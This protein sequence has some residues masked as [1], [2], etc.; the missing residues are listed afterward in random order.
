[1]SDPILAP[2]RVEL[3]ERV[4]QGLASFGYTSNALKEIVAEGK[5][6]GE[7]K[8]APA[9]PL[10]CLFRVFALHDPTPEEILRRQLGVEFYEACQEAGLWKREGVGVISSIDLTIQVDSFLICDSGDMRL[11]EIGLYWVMRAGLS[12]QLVWDAVPVKPYER[13]LDL[14]CGSGVLAFLLAPQAK[15]IVAVDRNPRA[16]NFGRFGAAM[17]GLAHVEFRES[18]CYSAVA[19]ETFDAIVCNPPFVL[20]PDRQNYYRDG[21]MDGDG[22]AQQVL[23]EAPAHLR[24]GGMAFIVCDVAATRTEASEERLCG[25]L[26]ARGCDVFAIGEPVVE[27]RQYA[28]GWLRIEPEATKQQQEERW[29]ERFDELGVTGIRNWLVVLRK[30]T[31]GGPNWVLLDRFPAKTEGHF[32]H[33]IDRRFRCQD[34]VRMEDAAFWN[35]RLRLAPDARI[36]KV[37]RP[38]NGQWVAE[39]AEVTFATGLMDRSNVDPR[40]VDFLLLFDGESTMEEVLMQVAGAMHAP[41]ERIRGGWQQYT[42]Q[43]TSDG[44]LEPVDG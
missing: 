3:A 25:W 2:L 34:V 1:M 6:K 16:V 42:K 31:E 32:G 14:C 41:V 39:E 7:T 4:G 37:V 11:S 5:E 44:I 12:T 21:G 33:Q 27:A 29:V 24:E 8:L 26:A 17:N 28:K 10:A 19:G 22:F 40:T 38:E 36:R 30:R 43:L 35:V 18:D 13:V 20:S 23:H 9:T 15:E